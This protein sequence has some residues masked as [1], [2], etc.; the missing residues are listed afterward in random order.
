MRHFIFFLALIPCVSHADT[1]VAAHIIRAH[2]VINADSIIVKPITIAGAIAD[3][4]QVLG[5]EARV[6]IYPGRPIRLGDIGP[7]ALI[8][9]NQIVTLIYA[10]SGLSILTEGRSLSRAGVGERARIMNLN[11]RK[12]I[13]GIVQP[14]GSVQVS[15]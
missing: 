8:E 15:Y 5:M 3:P 9:R 11:S 6:A 2:S 7:P 10:Q 12:S 13:V 14:D 1:I 4:A